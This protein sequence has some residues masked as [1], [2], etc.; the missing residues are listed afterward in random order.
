MR[1]R[2][3]NVTEMILEPVAD[4]HQEDYEIDLKIS[5]SMEDVGLLKVALM[6]EERGKEV[7]PGCVLQ[8][9]S[10]RS[11]K[12]LPKSGPEEGGESDQDSRTLDWIRLLKQR[13]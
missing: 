1:A 5:E 13:T 2:R 11:G 4:L 8:G 9:S 12:D 6:L 7:L 3:E 10:S